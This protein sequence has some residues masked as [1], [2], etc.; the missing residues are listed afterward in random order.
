MVTTQDDL[1]TSRDPA[2]E[3]L[4]EQECELVSLHRRIVIIMGLDAKNES[5][6]VES[7]TEITKISAMDIQESVDQLE[8]FAG[9]S[10]LKGY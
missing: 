7:S 10:G 9:I 6:N 2:I 3:N 4:L 5:T 8:N 1:G